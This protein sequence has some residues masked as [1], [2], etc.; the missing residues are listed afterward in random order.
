MT[1]NN[2]G[3]GVIG[4]GEPMDRGGLHLSGSWMGHSRR[5]VPPAVGRTPYV[6]GTWRNGGGGGY[7]W[8]GG[9]IGG[10]GV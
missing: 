9:V 6:G 2:G 10:G 8:G 4:G 3:G 7:R 5:S 1:E